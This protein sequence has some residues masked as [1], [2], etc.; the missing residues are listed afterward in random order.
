MSNVKKFTFDLDFDAPDEPEVKEPEVEEEVEPEIVVPTFSEEELAEARTE[1]FAAGKEEGRRE[2]ADATEQRLLESIEKAS[3]HLTDIFTR[4]TEANAEIAREMITISTA[5]ARKMFPDLNARNAL[6][7]VERVVQETL[8]AVTEE[9]RIQIMVNPEIREPLTERMAIMTQRA[10][11]E[12]K[13]FVTPDPAM[14]L[15]DCRIEWSNGAAVRD[16]GELWEMID[17]IIEHN[18]HG[19]EKDDGD[20]PPSAPEETTPEVAATPQNDAPEASDQQVEQPDEVAE[21]DDFADQSPSW[22]NEIS[23][24]AETN[25]AAMP[26]AVEETADETTDDG[27]R[28]RLEDNYNT[29]DEP[30]FAPSDDSD[31]AASDDDNSVLD[32]DFVEGDPFTPTPLA[33]APESPSDGRDDD[34]VDE[35]DEKAAVSNPDPLSP[36]TA[37]AILDAQG[38][39]NDDD[40]RDPSGQ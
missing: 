21:T 28:D 20:V 32:Q 29:S 2:A 23:E 24:S 10:G 9:P 31:E 19:P 1:S 27:F 22:E 25:A 5:I 26:D 14:P 8:K 3:G 35:P 37:T 18:L 15:G 30:P 33:E 13:V 40:E 38:T 39:M 17:K 34:A 7:E 12:G 16:A 36:A 11:F 4:Q 6:G